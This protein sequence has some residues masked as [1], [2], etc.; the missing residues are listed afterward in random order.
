MTDE[1]TRFEIAKLSL[2]KGD[3]LVVKSDLMLTPDEV[4]LIRE[5]FKRYVPENTEVI[6]VGSGLSIEVLSRL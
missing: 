2:R 5:H 4:K 3:S 1:V 6:V